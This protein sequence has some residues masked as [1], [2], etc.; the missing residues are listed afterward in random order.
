MIQIPL[1]NHRMPRCNIV[2]HALQNLLHLP[3]P[4]IG[5]SRKCMYTVYNQWLTI[6]AFQ[7]RPPPMP[8]KKLRPPFFSQWTSLRFQN[9]IPRHQS[10]RPQPRAFK[11]HIL[12]SHRLSQCRNRRFIMRLTCRHNIRP[13]PLQRLPNLPRTIHRSLSSH[14]PPLPFWSMHIPNK[15]INII[16]NGNHILSNM[17]TVND[18]NLTHQF[19][20]AIKRC[21]IDSPIHFIYIAF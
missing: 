7:N 10:P 17:K 12:K 16:R 20:E 14:L 4:H 15:T 2:F 18:P 11:I 5:P 6:C 8:R 13:I 19:I 1:H 9:F 3:I 21:C